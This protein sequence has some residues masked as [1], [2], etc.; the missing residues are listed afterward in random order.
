MSVFDPRRLL[1][2]F[3]HPGDES[4]FAGH[5]ISQALERGVRVQVLTLTRGERGRTAV[6]ALESLN[7]DTTAMALYRE[8][9]L[10]LALDALGGPQHHFAGTRAYLDSGFRVN[11]WGRFGRRRKVDELS[12]TA[13][14]TAIVANDILAAMREFRPDTVITHS[15]RGRNSLPDYRASYLATAMAIRKYRA[16]NVPPDLFVVGAPGRA[17]VEISDRNAASKQAALAAHRSQVEISRDGYRRG[18][19]SGKFLEP[20]K[21]SRASVNPVIRLVPLLTYFWALPLGALVA[22]AGT[23][24]HQ[25]RSSDQAPIGLAIALTMIGSLAIALRLL[26]NSRGALYLVSLAFTVGILIMAQRQGAGTVLIPGNE[27]GTI[28]AYGS[29]ILLFLIMLFPNLSR[30][31]WQKRAS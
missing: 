4:V 1:L 17:D 23:L 24:I 21:L 20:E 25:V 31:A 16:E 10:A 5:I 6:R 2:I 11:A 28:W 15:S 9:E 8:A 30:S 12:L 22:V 7:S 3:A 27:A 26:R 19:Q 18:Y 13:A 14:S 29:L